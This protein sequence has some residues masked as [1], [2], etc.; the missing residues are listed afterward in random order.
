MTAS[1]TGAVMKAVELGG[2]GMKLSRLQALR[3]GFRDFDHD[4]SFRF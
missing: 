2:A 1:V 3:R 4:L